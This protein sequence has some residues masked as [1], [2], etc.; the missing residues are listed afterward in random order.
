MDS[1]NIA[2]LALIQGITEFLPAS[3]SGHLI[4]WPLLTGQADQ[5][6]MM[7][8]AVH[9]GTLAAVCVYF[10]A[11]F[12]RLVAGL[13]DVLRGRLHS[14]AARL[15]LLVAL[16]T[17]PAVL[18]GLA[19]KLAGATEGL[20]SVAVVGWA[21]LLGA[22]L[23]WWADRVG[24]QHRAGG[25]WRLRDA[26]VMGLLQAVALI[27]G[28]SR[29]GITM[30]GARFLG[31]ERAEAARLSLLMAIPVTFAAGTLE[32]VEL[33]TDGNLALTQELGLGA[34]LSFLAAL[35]ALTV[36]MRMFRRDWTM[37]PFVLYRIALGV[38]LLV[39]AYT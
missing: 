15:C 10:R 29:S 14:D 22:G 20:R 7:D 39:F 2:I 12:L 37:L 26:V 21:T 1:L 23:L 35:A 8:V 28:T 9:I 24:G 31:F 19:L 34:G 6:L 4:L 33:I 27:P 16:A 13:T 32:T 30:T 5:G 38:G 25:D 18:T 17:V 11:D 36:M 3:S